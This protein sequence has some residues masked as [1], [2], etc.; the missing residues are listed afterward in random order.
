MKTPKPCYK[1]LL[2]TWTR[3]YTICDD[4]EWVLREYTVSTYFQIHSIDLYEK[5]NQ[6]KG[7]INQV[8]GIIEFFHKEDIELFIAEVLE[9][10]YIMN[11]LK[12]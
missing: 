12:K 2:S 4:T 5:V 10:A 3:K 6:Y 8:S 9:P 7:R 1:E 11:Q